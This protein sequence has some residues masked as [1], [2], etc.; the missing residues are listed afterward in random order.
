[1]KNINWVGV[2]AVLCMMIGFVVVLAGIVWLMQQA[3]F[4]IFGGLR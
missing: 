4:V 3:L 2:V 1:M